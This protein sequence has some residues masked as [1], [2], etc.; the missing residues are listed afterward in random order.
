M[1]TAGWIRKQVLSHPDYKQD[2][3]VTDKMTADLIQLMKEVTEGTVPCPD[4]FGTLSSK[5]PKAYTVL[6]CPSSPSLK[7]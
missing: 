2:S 4:L 6:E 5:T 1:T 7:K 3:V